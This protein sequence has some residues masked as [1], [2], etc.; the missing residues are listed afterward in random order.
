MDDSIRNERIRMHTADLALR[1]QQ[2]STLLAHRVM[3]RE[4]ENKV[5][6]LR[7]A[8]LIVGSIAI[9][10]FLVA[11]FLYLYRKK[12]RALMQAES[13]RMASSLRLENIR[14][15]LSPH[16]IYTVL[17]QALLSRKQEEQ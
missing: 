14:T 3:I 6:K 16:F 17:N 2:D 7:Q 9:V 13:R 5:L 10:A 1:Y 11:F 4:A 15:R 8:H 12:R